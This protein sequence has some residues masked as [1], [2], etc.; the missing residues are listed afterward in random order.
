VK[1]SD[2]TT[3]RLINQQ[4]LEPKFKKPEA[5][6]SWMGAVQ[7]QD[8]G[9]VKWAIGQRV[10]GATD[11]SVEQAFNDGAMLRTHVLRPT[12][13]FV[14]PA[15]IRWMVSLTAPRINTTCASQYRNLGLNDMV[16]SQT[17]KILTNALKD[18]N[19]L[20]RVELAKILEQAKVETND[21][22]MSHLMMRAELDM[23]VCS[24]IKK[25]KT[26]YLR[27]V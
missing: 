12:W 2:I 1:A 9:G 11:A 18:G 6:V 7:A 19:N 16:F 13:H 14:T 26:I 24:G 17:N 4:V 5:L 23:V 21:I 20:T 10:K 3:H 25:R 8:F 15:D 22:R 27:P